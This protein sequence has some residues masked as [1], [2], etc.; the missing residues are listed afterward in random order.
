MKLTKSRGGGERDGEKTWT[1]A[2]EK[3]IHSQ[4]G[5]RKKRRV[6]VQSDIKI[7][8]FFSFFREEGKGVWA[9]SPPAADDAVVLLLLLLRRRRP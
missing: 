4:V 5:E 2:A 8:S 3:K 7:S 1:A 9:A 6:R